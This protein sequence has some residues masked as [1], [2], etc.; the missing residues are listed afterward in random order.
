MNMDE[1]GTVGDTLATGIY[2]G[3]AILQGN[4]YLAVVSVGWNPYFKN[5]KKTVEA[6]LLAELNDFYGEQLQLSLEGF[7]RSEANFESLDDLIS[8]IHSDI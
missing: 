7:L 2:Y 4:E 6:H 5:E 8:C 1:L 3:R